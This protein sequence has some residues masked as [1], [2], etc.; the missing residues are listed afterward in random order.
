[1]IFREGEESPESLKGTTDK[2]NTT[3]GGLQVSQRMTTKACI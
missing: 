3:N 1:M 2:A